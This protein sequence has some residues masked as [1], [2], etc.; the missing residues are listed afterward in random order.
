MKRKGVQSAMHLPNQCIRI[1]Q[2]ACR[3]GRLRERYHGGN[4]TF[5][6]RNGGPPAASS[7]VTKEDSDQVKS[8]WYLR[9]NDP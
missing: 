8:A 2:P 4:R 6:K 9:E 5:Q 1:G 3:Q 7:D